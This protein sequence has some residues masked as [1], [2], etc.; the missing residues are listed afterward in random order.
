MKLLFHLIC[1][2]MGWIASPPNICWSPSPQYLR[3]WPPLETGSLQVSLVRLKWGHIWAGWV[4]IWHPS[5]LDK[6]RRGTQKEETGDEDALRDPCQAEIQMLQLQS[7][8]CQ[9]LRANHQKLGKGKEGFCP[10]CFRGSIGPCQNLDF[11]LVASR[12]GK[13][14]FCCF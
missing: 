14:D 13:T 3:M 8:K 11:S 6:K 9:Q 4:L 5:V 1:V 7:K 2:V 12:L 10:M